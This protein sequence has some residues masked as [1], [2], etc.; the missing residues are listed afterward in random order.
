MC[1]VVCVPCA[2]VCV[3]VYVCVSRRLTVLVGF[4]PCFC[5][6]CQVRTFLDDKGWLT[7]CYSVLISSGRYDAVDRV[8]A[9]YMLP[10]SG[11]FLRHVSSRRGKGQPGLC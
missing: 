11:T 4:V 9:Q 10:K 8:S 1:A 6:L 3:R 2:Y 7:V 5:L